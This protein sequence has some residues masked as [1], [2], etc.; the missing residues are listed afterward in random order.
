[1]NTTF[2]DGFTIINNDPT[3][4]KQIATIIDKTK[5]GLAIASYQRRIIRTGYPIEQWYRRVAQQEGHP[6]FNQLP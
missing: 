3:V 2:D 5:E 4:K 6:V 1:M